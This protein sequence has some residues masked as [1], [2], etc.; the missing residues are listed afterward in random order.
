MTETAQSTAQPQV[1]R[2][3]LTRKDYE[4]AESTLCRGC[5]HDAITASII[6]ACYQASIDPRTVIKLSGIGCSAK[7]TNY[8][9]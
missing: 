7:T 2:L 8:F 1:N 3:R 6:Q 5:G 4:G 9:M